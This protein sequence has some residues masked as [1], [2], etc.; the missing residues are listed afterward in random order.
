MRGF[1]YIRNDP[2]N[3]WTLLAKY[4]GEVMYFDSIGDVLEYL[5]KCG[6]L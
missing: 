4:I 6:D 3:G 5:T 1:W 2:P